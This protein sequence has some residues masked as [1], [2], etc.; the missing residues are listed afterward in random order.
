MWSRRYFKQTSQN[1]T[2]S[3]ESDS[4]KSSG[5]GNRTNDDKNLTIENC[6]KS[7]LHSAL[8]GVVKVKDYI[9]LKSSSGS[10]ISSKDKN[11][12]QYGNLL[13]TVPSASMYSKIVCSVSEDDVKG[14]VIKSFFN[15]KTKPK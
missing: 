12:S 8:L 6:N 10:V 7:K 13:T 5:K 2:S 14:S 15:L 1:S 9:I 11:L 4:K 3:H